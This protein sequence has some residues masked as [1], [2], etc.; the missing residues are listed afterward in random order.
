MKEIG[1]MIRMER[2]KRQLTL[3]Q[4][5]Q[6]TGLSRSFLSQIERGIGQASIT[7]LK[8]IAQHFGISVV[9]LFGDEEDNQPERGDTQAFQEKTYDSSTYVKEVQVVRAGKRKGFTLPGSNVRYELMTPD[10][11]RQVEVFSMRISKDERSGDEPLVALP[12]EKFGL[13]VRGTIEIRFEKEVH[14]LTPGDSIYF[15]AD[16]P[17]FWRGIEGDPIE[18]LWVMTPPSF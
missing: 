1:K 12:G 8:K 17:H 4:L 2:L 11:N 5:S 10:L 13:V 18:V 7:S 6:K 15:P 9:Q 3:E 14:Q 16:F